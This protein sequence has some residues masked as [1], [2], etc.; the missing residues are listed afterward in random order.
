[1]SKTKN[2]FIWIEGAFMNLI[3]GIQQECNRIR[4][5]R[6]SYEDIGDPG[7]FGLLMI[8]TSIKMAEKAIADGDTIEMIKCLEQLKGISN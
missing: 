5:I 7:K 8:D 3:E 4:G 2:K 6:K 1:M